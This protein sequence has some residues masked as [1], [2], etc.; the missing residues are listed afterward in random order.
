MIFM[1]FLIICTIIAI[2][3]LKPK[4]EK[5]KKRNP[6][7]EEIKVKYYGGF[8]DLCGKG[9]CIIIQEIDKIRFLI[10]K[11]EGGVVK[12]NYSYDNIKSCSIMTESQ[13]QEQV[14]LGKLLFF[15]A[16][17]FGMKGKQKEI[18]NEYIVLEILEGEQL[19]SVILQ[20]ELGNQYLYDMFRFAN[21]K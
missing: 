21:N 18:T 1:I 2:I 6:I 10:I 12:R 19:S 20:Y 14:S 8:K 3:L 15:G 13:I 17:A 16:L 11:D 7:I 4:K 9:S 5:E